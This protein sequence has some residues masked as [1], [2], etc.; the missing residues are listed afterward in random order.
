MNST[1]THT[2][3]PPADIR[4]GLANDDLAAPAVILAGMV[5]AVITGLGMLWLLRE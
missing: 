4:F 1:T 3:R 5:C 2:G